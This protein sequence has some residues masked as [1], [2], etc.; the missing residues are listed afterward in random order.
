MVSVS[1]FVS[2]GLQHLFSQKK[3]LDGQGSE[4]VFLK[5]ITE[6]TN[7]IDLSYIF[8]FSGGVLF[9][10]QQSF[11][12]APWIL[13]SQ[14]E[15]PFFYCQSGSL[16]PN[17]SHAIIS[18]I[19]PYE[20]EGSDM[21]SL[22]SFDANGIQIYP[23]ENKILYGGVILTGSYLAPTTAA[24]TGSTLY[25]SD[26]LWNSIYK[27]DTNFL[28]NPWVKII[29]ESS[30]WGTVAASWNP[31]SSFLNNP[32]W[33]TWWEN[34]LFIADTKNNR[35][36]KWDEY[37]NKIE[38]FLTSQDGL[39]EPTGLL[40]DDVRKSLFIVNSWKGE[41]L[42]YTSFSGSSIPNLDISFSPWTLTWVTQIRVE[43]LTT[44][45]NIS[46]TP[47]FS[48]IT[49]TEDYQ[50][51]S[52]DIFDYYISN[53]SQ[54]ETSSLNISLPWC[55]PSTR[56]YLEWMIP[57]KEVITCSSA[58]TGSIQ[59]LYW[60]NTLSFNYGTTYWINLQNIIGNFSENKS[61]AAK[62]SLL[63]A[64]GDI[65]WQN[66]Y[67]FFTKGDNKILT[68]SD[69]RL[70]V[71]K[72]GLQYPTGIY[73]S[74]GNIFI[75]DF[76]E[77]KKKEFDIA[78]IEIGSI[79]LAPFDFQNKSPHFSDTILSLPTSSIQSNIWGNMFDLQIQ[80]FKNFSCF[81]DSKSILKT[82][83]LKKYIWN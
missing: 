51:G 63:N 20:W 83:L 11:W 58:S 72:S 43:F 4:M 46:A 34:S 7:S 16:Y 60:N 27:F 10:T 38:E 36:L 66:Y 61:Y 75:Y 35:I 32:T 6:Y 65:V 62:L 17:T 29:W 21:S 56:K 28:W 80:Y 78:W 49:L 77:R 76:F 8:S 3:M 73:K 22:K 33:L 40:Y 13:V 74:W 67:P 55:T 12:N 19:F 59:K 45:G 71:L 82:L 69:N 41:I 53:F 70:R 5:N 37:S 15:M 52:T 48:G 26:T 30:F 14:K 44:W 24:L 18:Q 64:T 23:Y 47:A 25:I 54:T 31:L 1:V 9:H 57:K 50:T 2:W 81:D 68:A 79:N 42:E 39:K